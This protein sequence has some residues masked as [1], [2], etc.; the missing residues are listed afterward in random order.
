MRLE[1]A[2]MM[3]MNYLEHFVGI[4]LWIDH[5]EDVPKEITFIEGEPVLLRK[6]KVLFLSFTDIKI[7]LERWMGGS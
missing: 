7:C 3:R 2:V 1:A 4:Y 6:R 5:V